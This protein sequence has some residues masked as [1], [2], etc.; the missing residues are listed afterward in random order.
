MLRPCFLVLDR[1]FPGSISTRKLV[2][3]TAKFNVITA[4][5]AEEAVETL[6]AFPAIHGVVMDA[7][8]HGVPCDELIDRLKELQPRIRVVAI[9]G[10]RGSVCEGADYHLESFDPRVLLETLRTLQPEEV[11]EIEK[12][13]E[14]L[15]RTTQSRRDRIRGQNK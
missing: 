2:I 5:S 3:E 6:A 7:D 1:E 4:Y 11:A 13:E 14:Q 10:P 9:S 12:Q 15:A 8:I